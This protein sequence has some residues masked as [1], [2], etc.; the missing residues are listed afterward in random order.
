MLNKT[1]DDVLIDLTV[2]QLSEEYGIDK[3]ILLNKIIK[4]EPVNVVK[5]EPQ[6]RFVYKKSKNCVNY[7]YII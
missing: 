3:N 6:K 2:N 1:N 4:V 5:V 7:C